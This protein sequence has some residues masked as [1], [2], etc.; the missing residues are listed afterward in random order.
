[1]LVASLLA[2]AALA[3]ADE[4]LAALD[5]ELDRILLN[6]KQPGLLLSAHVVDLT[7]HRTLYEN[8]ADQP[9]MPASVMKLVV[10]S[11]ALDTL[12]PDFKFVTRLGLLHDDLVVIG[13]GDPT[14]GD[15]KLAASGMLNTWAE[16][17]AAQKIR[18]ITG[19]LIIDDSIFDARFTHPAWPRDQFQD[20]YEAPIGGLNFAD[21]CVEVEVAPAKPGAPPSVT[22]NPPSAFIDLA[23]RAQ[24]AAKGAK[25]SV[26]AR[27]NLGSAQIALAGNCSAPI[28]LGPMSVSDPGLFFAGCLRA[29]LEKNGI[30]IDGPTE[31]RRILDS[32]ANTPAEFRQIASA[33]SPLTGAARR[34]CTDSLG[35]MAEGV[36]K[37][38]GAARARPGSWTTGAAAVAAFINKLG[39]S[40][41]AF[42]IDD[43]SG[44]SRRNRV[45]ARA[46]T[47]ILAH[48]NARPARDALFASLAEPGKPGTLQKRLRE[49]RGRIHAK[50]GYIN[51]VRT[52]AGYIDAADGHRIA[53]AILYNGARSTAPLTR[54]QD[55]A[56]RLLAKWPDIKPAV[57]KKSPASTNPKISRK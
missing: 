12:G 55:E 25:N 48:M 22:L 7:N 13:G 20:W 44:L 26:S 57:S 52:L 33:E 10:C 43:G 28:V 15:E 42:I 50:T 9:L 56:C 40:D 8:Q 4:R 16:K 51:G 3:V 46:I 2:P 54:A 14:F 34:A 49:L 53:F 35:M 23:N 17:L 11:A 30:T 41:G 36:I 45:S 38:L 37:T 47:A 31:R 24:S 18:R 32:F 21:N 6:Q 29:A 19:K 27:R 1:L 39:I 5:A